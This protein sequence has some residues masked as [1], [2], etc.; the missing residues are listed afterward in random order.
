MRNIYCIYHI[1]MVFQGKVALRFTDPRRF[2]AMLWTDQAPQLHALIA[3]LGPEP[4]TDQFNF[5][6][7]YEKSRNRKQAIKTFIMDS[8]IVVGV[9]NIYANEALFAAGIRPTKP[10]GKLTKPKLELLV[11]EIKRVLNQAIEQGGTTLRDFTGGDGKPGY[12]AQALAVYGRGEKP[13]RQCASTLTEIRLG[14]RSTVYC[15]Y[16]QK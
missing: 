13:C 10:A 9:G 16:C 12:F 6:Y 14:N 15:R 7:L 3:H 5:S 8:K 4:L 1:D 11:Q 2:G